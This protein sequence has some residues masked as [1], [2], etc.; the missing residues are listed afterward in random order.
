MKPKKRIVIIHFQPLEFYPPIQ[1]LLSV[2]NDSLTNKEIIVISTSQ[3]KLH[4][5]KLDSNSIKIFRK[6]ITSS[7]RM[8]RTLKY[9]YF[10]FF[11]FIKLL[12]LRSNHVIYFET[13]SA[14]PAILYKFIFP[15]SKLIVHYHEYTSLNEY[16][17]GMILNKF[18]FL[19]ERKLFHKYSWI[20]HTNKD[21]VNL[22][23]NDI[24]S[25]KRLNIRIMPN[26]PTKSWIDRS[27]EHF[28]LSQ[29]SFGDKLNLVYI[30]ALSFE[31]TY[32][33]EICDFIIKNHLK[34]RLDIYAVTCT[35]EVLTYIN[36][37]S[38]SIIT[39]KGA[40]HYN[41]I[42]KLL[43]QYQVG[44]I[45]YKGT[46]PNFVYNAPNK[47]FEYMCSGLDVWYPSEMIGCYEYTTNHI[48]KVIEINF[49]SIQ[50]S[51]EEYQFEYKALPDYKYT[52]E[53][54]TSD[55]IEFLK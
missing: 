31:D 30:G 39:Y 40:A 10:Y 6:Q 51:I 46:V 41:E 37:I 24:N 2:L 25:D 18:N 13:I 32:I 23:L 44:L 29:V 4:E 22:F 55:L 42:P 38:D 19:L 43:T 35:E 5:F 52:T 47:L 9:I 7:K 14:L 3:N 33:R 26:Y 27:I 11:C 20:S 28:Q 36:K 54:A 21:R 48:P 50:K 34:F 17:N 53:I 8:I 16:K 45:L 12:L 49:R 15:R 1:N